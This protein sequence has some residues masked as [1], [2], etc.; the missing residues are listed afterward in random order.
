MSTP[1]LDN[2]QGVIDPDVYFQLNKPPASLPEFESKLTAFVEYHQRLDNK[3]VF[4]TSGGTTVP[5]EN[6]TVLTV[7]EVL[8][9]QSI[10]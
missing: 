4:I 8:F 5:L 10:L 2:G 3:I 1:I 9:Q 7:L 6:Q